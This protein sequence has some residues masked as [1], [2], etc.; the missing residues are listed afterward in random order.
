M[1]KA[2]FDSTTLTKDDFTSLLQ[3]AGSLGAFHRALKMGLEIHDEYMSQ[4]GNCASQDYARLNNFPILC[5]E[6]GVE[7]ETES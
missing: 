7:L 2:E 6:L 3:L 5:R 1:S 4:I